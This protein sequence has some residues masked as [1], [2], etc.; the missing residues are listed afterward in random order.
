MTDFFSD[1]SQA[2]RQGDAKKVVQMVKEA[3]AKGRPP[4][5]FW[6]RVWYPVCKP[7]GDYLKMG[8]YIYRRY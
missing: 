5:I 1:L 6:R 2:V 8:K 3:L 7:W 4:Q